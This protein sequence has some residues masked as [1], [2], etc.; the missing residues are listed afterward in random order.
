MCVKQFTL[1]YGFRESRCYLSRRRMRE[2]INRR[3]YAAD[4]SRRL[5]VHPD[6]MRVGKHATSQHIEQAGFLA[7]LPDRDLTVPVGKGGGARTHK[8]AR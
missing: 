7:D 2:K 6:A 5:H 1:R 3:H 8:A 4:G